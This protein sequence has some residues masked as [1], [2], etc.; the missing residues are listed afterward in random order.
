MKQGDGLLSWILTSLNPSPALT[1][2]ARGWIPFDD[3]ESYLDFNYVAPVIDNVV[4]VQTK[5]IHG[6]S[7]GGGEAR[8]WGFDE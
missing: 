1:L 5:L 4:P 2:I 6:V 8:R 7:S 3:V